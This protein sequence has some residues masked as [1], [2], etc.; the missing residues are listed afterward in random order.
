MARRVLVTGASGFIGANLA[1]RLLADGNEVHLLLRP[2]HQPWRIEEIRKDVTVHNVDL[3]DRDG[4]EKA[5]AKARPDWIFHL[6]AHGAYPE[7]RDF[8]RMIVT[9]FH[10][11]GSLL[12]AAQ[13]AG[14][15]AFVNAG[16]SSEYGY[17]D[18]APTEDE[19]VEPNSPYAVSKAAATQFCR[20]TAQRAGLP[21]RTLRVYS[22]YGPYEEPTRLV[23]TLIVDGL[24]GRLPPLVNPDIARDYVHVDD[25]CDAFVLAAATPDQEPGVIYNVGTGIQTTLRQIVEVTRRLLGVDAEPQWGSMQARSWDTDVWVSNPAKIKTTLGW[26]PRHDLEGGLRETV[27]W[28]RSN[29]D[30]VAQYREKQAPALRS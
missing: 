19:L 4:P 15:E 5:V 16:T 21:V 18:H 23:P 28:F 17:K 10:G 26:F 13:S 9:N 2:S 25:V 22:A 20:M 14:F 6:A 7:Q 1:R 27:E 24:E 12:M 30:R 11:T 8:D 3:D 29:P